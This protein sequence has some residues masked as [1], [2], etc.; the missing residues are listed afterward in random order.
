MNI[1]EFASSVPLIAPTI[2]IIRLVQEKTGKDVEFVK[3]SSLKVDAQ[4]KIARTY[5]DKHIITY[6]SN[7]SENINHLI[8]HECGHIFRFYS[9]DPEKRLGPCTSAEYFKQA[10]LDIEKKSKS[11]LKKLPPH[12]SSQLLNI[13]IHGII[14]QLTNIPVDYYIE[15][16][17]YNDYPEMREI[18]LKSLT[19]MYN[20]AARGLESN[21]KKMTPEIIFV[22]SNAMNYAFYKK[23]DLSLGTNFFNAYRYFSNKKIGENLFNFINDT[24]EGFLSDIDII[25]KW[26]EELKLTKWFGWVQIESVA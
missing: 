11:L 17:I 18:Q 1:S 19:S 14:R 4:V 15:V 23:L 5:M 26:A 9:V 13:W 12:A 8:A 7:P 3:D 22:A 16:W 20:D 24:D 25:N 6:R 21:L 2:D 10:T